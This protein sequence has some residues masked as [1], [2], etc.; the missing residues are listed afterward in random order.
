MPFILAGRGF[1]ILF[2]LSPEPSLLFLL[3]V[4]VVERIMQLA[5]QGF[6]PMGL[7]GAG[8]SCGR[9]QGRQWD[10]REMLEGSAG[11]QLGGAPWGDI[12]LRSAMSPKALHPA[13]LQAEKG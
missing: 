9:W 5:C 1:D 10:V 4:G 8:G 12:P 2:E 7:Q 11:C 6:L 3:V 13:S